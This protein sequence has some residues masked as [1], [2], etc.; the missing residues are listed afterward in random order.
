M[1]KPA[2]LAIISEN[3]IIIMSMSPRTVEFRSTKI[4]PETNAPDLPEHMSVSDEEIKSARRYTEVLNLTRRMYHAGKMHTLR[5]TV[6]N[7]HMS[8][9]KRLIWDIVVNT[10]DDDAAAIQDEHLRASLLE[11]SDYSDINPIVETLIALHQTATLIEIGKTSAHTFRWAV[12]LIDLQQYELSKQIAS[13]HEIGVW[14][15]RNP[16][17]TG[18]PKSLLG[19]PFHLQSDFIDGLIAAGNKR[20]AQA[21]ARARADIVPRHN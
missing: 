15:G 20:L 16:D 10:I 6:T 19:W 2:N 21:A 18:L 13:A 4:A 3:Y 1:T 12:A 9:G 14:Y 17:N 7:I 8:I 11:L 5:D